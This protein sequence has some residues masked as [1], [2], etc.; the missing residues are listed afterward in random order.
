MNN[1]FGI[2]MPDFGAIADLVKFEEADYVLF[3]KIIVDGITSRILAGVT[4]DGEALDENSL[5]WIA[6]KLREG[7]FTGP[8]QYTGGLREARTYQVAF[9]GELATI[10][11]IGS[12]KR[13]HIDLNE[14]SDRTGKNYSAWFG[15]AAEDIGYIMAEAELILAEKLRQVL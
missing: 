14:I 2:T 11:L 4:A 13:I 3:A 8:L 12:Y 6:Q 9:D 15:I 5:G 7:R 10:E 1:G